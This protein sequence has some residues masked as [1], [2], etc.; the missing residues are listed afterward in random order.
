MQEARQ[1]S[2]RRTQWCGSFLV[3]QIKKQAKDETDD[4]TS[5][6]GKVEREV[7]FFDQE[8]PG[9]SAQGDMFL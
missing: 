5:R 8:I 4:E 2:K 3:P 7:F 9:Q 1:G 6:Y